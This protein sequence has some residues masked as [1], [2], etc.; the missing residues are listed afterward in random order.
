MRVLEEPFLTRDSILRV[1]RPAE[2]T[3]GR[4]FRLRAQHAAS[5]GLSV[6][7]RTS[8]G[9]FVGRVHLYSALNAD[10]ARAYRLHEK[11]AAREL[12]KRAAELEASPAA[13]TIVSA[14]ASVASQMPG[15]PLSDQ[16]PA[17]LRRYLA[18][19]RASSSRG[20]DTGALAREWLVQSAAWLAAESE[21]LIEAVSQLGRKADEAR[22]QVLEGP[23]TATTFYG[24][25]QRMDPSAAEIEG[26]GGETM[27]IPRMDLEREGLAAI[28]QPVSLLQE[29][30]P[31]GG[32]YWL[33]MP[34]VALD[35]D[36][37]EPAAES[38]LNAESPLMDVVRAEGGAL[39]AHLPPADRSWFERELAR[40]PTAVP[41]APLPV[42]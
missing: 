32:S 36:P 19:R 13:A 41:A 29:A 37:G 20:L 40:E 14:I 42:R 18:Q 3:T 38:S 39:V 11:T 26:P 6:P 33:P 24:V 4:P 2:I 21:E 15:D 22:A 7:V 10:A 27:L 17:H 31:G 28:G 25:V 16:A 34:A 9:Q 1:Y 8:L 5:H 35:V 30:L 23:F 12:A